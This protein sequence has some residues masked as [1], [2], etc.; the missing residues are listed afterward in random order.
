MKTAWAQRGGSQAT[1]LATRPKM[2]R[3][4]RTSTPF[5]SASMIKSQLQNMGP[6]PKANKM[7]RSFAG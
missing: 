4:L 7:N 6:N 3:P 5:F 1:A 2:G